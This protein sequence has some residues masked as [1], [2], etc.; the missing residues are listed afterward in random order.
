MLIKNSGD[1]AARHREK[2]ATVLGFLGREKWS[3]FAT[4]NRLFGFKNHRGLYD[5]L[6]KLVTEGTLKKHRI[7]RLSLWSL[8]TNEPITLSPQTVQTKL[9]AQNARFS[10]EAMGAE[11]WQN[12]AEVIMPV[13]LKH[14]PAALITMPDGLRVALEIHTRMRTQ[15]RYK[16]LVKHHLLA[17]KQQLWRTVF[18]VFS[19]AHQRNAGR[20]IINSIKNITIAGVKYPLEPVHHDTFRYVTLD[21][22]KDGSIDL[23]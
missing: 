15:A 7:D 4:I 9:A 8:A 3:D 1:R 10:F 18:F 23:R 5:L 20:L 17:R 12:G 6:N 2:I 14:K 13:G 16:E 21:E 19:S 11:N 22:L